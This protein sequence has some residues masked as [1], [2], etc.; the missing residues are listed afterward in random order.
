VQEYE[1]Y[2]PLYYNDGNRIE[3]EKRLEIHDRRLREFDGFTYFAHPAR[4]Y[5]K[6]GGVTFRDMVVIYRIIA[7]NAFR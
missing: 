5:W 6:F 1:L 2:V 3:D 7:F 4:S